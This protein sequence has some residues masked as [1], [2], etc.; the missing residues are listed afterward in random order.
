[1]M[2][3]AVV[4]ATPQHMRDLAS[5]EASA[6]SD[7]SDPGTSIRPSPEESSGGASDRLSAEMSER[8]SDAEAPS[9]GG[10]SDVFRR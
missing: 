3:T 4:K 1:M 2:S 9:K 8:A 6:G 7:W 10:A 5:V